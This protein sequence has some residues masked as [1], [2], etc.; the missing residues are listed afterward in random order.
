MLDQRIE[1]SGLPARFYTDPAIL[2]RE[3]EAHFANGWVGGRKI[4]GIK[5]GA[6]RRPEDSPHTRTLVH[7]LVSDSQRDGKSAPDRDRNPG[8]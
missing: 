1:A 7:V 4:K 6:A 8:R 2:H 3:I 5:D